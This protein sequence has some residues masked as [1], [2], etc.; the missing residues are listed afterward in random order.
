MKLGLHRTN[1]GISGFRPDTG[2][3]APAAAGQASILSHLRV[4]VARMDDVVPI[5]VEVCVEGLEGAALAVQAGASRLEVCSALALGGV[6]PGPGLWQAVR[7]AVEVPLTV[8]LRPRRGDFCYAAGEMEALELEVAYA[9][10]NGAHGVALGCLAQNGVVDR[11]R[12]ARL[13]DLARPLEVTFHRAF[14]HVRDQ[15]EALEVLADLGVERVLSSGAATRAVDGLERLSELVRQAGDRLRVVPAAGIGPENG[16]RILEATG[17]R[18]LHLS[19]G[20]VQI[21]AAWQPEHVCRLGADSLPSEG[22]R[23]VTD[24]ARIRELVE[25]LR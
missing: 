1:G 4:I 25:G 17:A 16:R 18:D 20:R 9:R 22:E 10:E 21:S 23:V 5:E 3:Q 13:V 12:T 19:A 7:R 24:G 8:L 14:D 15:E 6:T 2:V 11:E